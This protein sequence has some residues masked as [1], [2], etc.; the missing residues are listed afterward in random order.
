MLLDCRVGPWHMENFKQRE[1]EAFQ[2]ER[3]R[4]LRAVSEVDGGG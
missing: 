3:L 1:L 4:R 2:A